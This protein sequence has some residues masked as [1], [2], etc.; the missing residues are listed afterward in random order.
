MKH[1]EPKKHRPV[2]LPDGVLIRIIVDTEAPVDII[3]Q[4]LADYVASLPTVKRMLAGQ[5]YIIANL[6]AVASCN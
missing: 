4:H 1:T 5:R 2:T 6:K 3:E